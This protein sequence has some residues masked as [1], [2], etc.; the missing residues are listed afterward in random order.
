MFNEGILRL[1]LCILWGWGSVI[2]TPQSSP[3]HGEQVHTAV[4]IHTFTQCITTTLGHANKKRQKYR[5][6]AH[7]GGGE[8]ESPNRKCQ[9]AEHDA[10]DKWFRPPIQSIALFYFS[11]CCIALHNVLLHNLCFLLSTIEIVTVSIWALPVD[12]LV[13]HLV[14]LPN[15]HCMALP[16]CQILH[17]GSFL[18]N[19]GHF[20]GKNTGVLQA[21]IQ[22]KKFVILSSFCDL[23][24]VQSVIDLLAKQLNPI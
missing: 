11:I 3:L 17:T 9:W 14:T 4:V 2:E 16:V 13:N 20:F 7:S 23:V 19:Y 6:C 24:H 8:V 18:S 5:T 10:H 1:N 22:A 15:L 12:H 21:K